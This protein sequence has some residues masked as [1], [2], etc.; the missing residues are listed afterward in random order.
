MADSK[1]GNR[2]WNGA[3]MREGL[4]AGRLE[5]RTFTG[6]TVDTSA[7]SA[8]SP[9]IVEQRDALG[10]PVRVRRVA[11]RRV[12]SVK[13]RQV[14][15]ERP[16]VEV[17]GTWSAGLVEARLRRIGETFRDMPGAADIW[18]AGYKSCMPTPVRELWHDMPAE[19]RRVSPG[20]EETD[21]AVAT[22]QSVL[23]AVFDIDDG[24]ALALVEAVAHAQK[25]RQVARILRKRA[26]CQ[27]LSYKGAQIRARRL[28]ADIATVWSRKNLAYDAVD[29]RRAV[30]LAATGHSVIH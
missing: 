7:P 22:W 19:A 23:D 6:A 16:V 9:L 3:A 1:S 27:S 29:V 30:S 18:P 4:N 26:N 15:A 12:A 2:V 28:L 20:R 10:F 14:A 8:L 21:L 25:W 11:Y 5:V 17:P 13:L 24:T